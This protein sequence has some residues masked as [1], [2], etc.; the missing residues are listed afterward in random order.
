MRK[1]RC[2]WAVAVVQWQ[3]LPHVSQVMC[4]IDDKAY[5]DKIYRSFFGGWL[6]HQLTNYFESLCTSREVLNDV[7]ILGSREACATLSPRR[8]ACC[9]DGE[10]M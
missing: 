10:H 5:S 8:E 2:L 6:N 1:R 9:G 4:F 7:L 3:D